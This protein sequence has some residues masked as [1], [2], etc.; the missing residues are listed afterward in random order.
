LWPNAQPATG[1]EA[2]TR[3][4]RLNRNVEWK[5]TTIPSFRGERRKIDDMNKTTRL[6]GALAEVK[7]TGESL[8]LDGPLGGGNTTVH[9]VLAE[10]A[11]LPMVAELVK[12]QTDLTS[13]KMGLSARDI[14][15]RISSVLS[16]AKNASSKQVQEM[17]TSV[18]SPCHR[19]MAEL[20]L[21]WRAE[22]DQAVKTTLDTLSR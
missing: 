21:K 13:K 3:A 11:A 5:P 8:Q 18:F 9:K 1:A 14:K 19:P 20:A 16:Q 17:K 22:A 7:V 10:N 4:A 6:L 15:R 12:I 2:R